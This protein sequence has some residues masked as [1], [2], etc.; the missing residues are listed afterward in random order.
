MWSPHWQP[1]LLQTQQ[2]IST[3]SLFLHCDFFLLVNFSTHICIPSQLYILQIKWNPVSFLVCLYI[4]SRFS[5]HLAGHS[6]CH[7]SS[8]TGYSWH[9]VASTH[10]LDMYQEGPKANR[11]WD[12][13]TKLGI[14]FNT[15]PNSAEQ[16][17][18]SIPWPHSQPNESHLWHS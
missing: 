9:C 16:P 6:C 11:H 7:I 14:R 15:S 10:L 17:N 8:S 13:R 2:V 4:M 5:N 12:S 3:L 1:W 18:A